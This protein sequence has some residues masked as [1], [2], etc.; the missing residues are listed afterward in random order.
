MPGRDTNMRG[1][2]PTSQPTDLEAADPNVQNAPWVL[3]GILAGVIGAA[4]VAILFLAFDALEGRALWTPYALGAGLFRGEIPPP[5]TPIEPVF[6]LAYTVLHGSVFA[7]VGLLAASELMTGSR[8][9][10]AGSATRAL[11]LAG[12]LFVAFGAIFAGFA[13][14]GVPGVAQLFG[15]GRIALANLVASAAMAIALTYR[16]ERSAS[17]RSSGS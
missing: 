12:L 11:A 14:L 10:A 17:A 9:P 7:A 5:G 6:A 4:I 13:A 1:S 2:Q 16:S 15:I 8:L 3:E